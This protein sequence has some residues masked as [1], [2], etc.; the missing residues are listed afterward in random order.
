MFRF[1]NVV[2]VA[3][4]LFLVAGSAVASNFRAADQVYIP[5]A[6]HFNASGGTFISDVTI[7]NLSADPVTISVIYTP[8]SFADLGATRQTPQY[9]NDRITL[10]A[11]ERRDIRDF[12][13]SA[14][15]LGIAPGT[16]GLVFGTLVFNACRTGSATAC[17]TGQDE[18]GNHPD[19]R[20]I[21]VAS[22]IYFAGPNAATAGTTAQ[23][24][25]GIPWYNY[26]SMR[27][28]QAPAGNLG[29]VVIGGITQNGPGANTFRSNIGVMNASQYSTTTLRLRLFQGTTQLGQ[30]DITLGPLNHVQGAVN[31]IFGAPFGN[32]PTGAAAVNMHVTVEQINSTAEPG[33]PSTCSTDGCPGF[34]AYGALLDN[35]SSDPVTLEAIYE[36][37]LSDDALS[38]IYGSSA[39][40]SVY[41]RI[42][43][44]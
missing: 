30:R 12:M 13:S 38:A 29:R 39:G 44:R 1:K 28:S 20:N 34:L 36:Q 9:F 32:V 16:G 43:R 35:L 15:G 6:G 2:T 4:L 22:R 10:A 14:E 19:Y 25:P 8:S 42:V 3:A 18:F 37:P 5:A 26:V 23:F 24:F 27:A 7:Q 41:R 17:R 40:K 33:A 21:A 11:F 31:A